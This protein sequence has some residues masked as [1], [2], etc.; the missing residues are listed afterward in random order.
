MRGVTTWLDDVSWKET[1][2]QP[3]SSTMT[4][5]TNFGADA[6]SAE[7]ESASSSESA[8]DAARAARK[9]GMVGA[10]AETTER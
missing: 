8:A 9:A 10:C 6:G 5:S 3:R 7:A 2:P 1:S 4:C